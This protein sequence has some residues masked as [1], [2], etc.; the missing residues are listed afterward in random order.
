MFGADR[1]NVITRKSHPRLKL[2]DLQKNR[3]P[4]AVRKFLLEKT[5]EFFKRA[6]FDH[7]FFAGP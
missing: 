4:F 1:A 5:P 7:H 2:E 3:H 6:G